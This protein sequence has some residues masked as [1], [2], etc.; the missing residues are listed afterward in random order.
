MAESRT[1]DLHERQAQPVGDVLHE[2]GL[3]IARRRDQQQHALTVGSLVLALGADLLGQIISDQRQIDLVD[4][5][6][7]NER[8]Q[9]VRLEFFQPEFLGVALH[10]L[11][12][13]LLIT[14]E[15]RNNVFLVV[16]QSSHEVAVVEP[17]RALLDQRVRA[18]HAGPFPLD[19]FSDD[20]SPLGLSLSQQQQ[21][22]HF[23]SV[24]ALIAPA[25][26]DQVRPGPIGKQPETTDRILR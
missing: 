16:S 18:H 8:R 6:V 12:A 15:L 1:V 19:A 23:L 14:R 3:A 22:G 4:E 7:A 24:F 9:D 11:P 10:Q 25:C 26:I 2:R 5:P 20:L 17:I 13:A 21:R